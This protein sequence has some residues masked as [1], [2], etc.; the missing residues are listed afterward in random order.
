M[1]TNVLMKFKQDLLFYHI[2][3]H[4]SQDISL[5]LNTPP[6]RIQYRNSPNSMAVDITCYTADSYCIRDAAA[7]GATRVAK[8]S[9]IHLLGKILELIAKR[10]G[11]IGGTFLEF[12]V[13]SPNF[14]RIEFHYQ[15]T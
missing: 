8:Y 13:H 9:P 5:C 1:Y 12:T 10:Y 14:F 6:L 7:A 3:G 11:E 4:S 15:G 2:F